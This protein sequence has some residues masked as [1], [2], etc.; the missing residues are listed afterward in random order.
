MQRQTSERA[1]ILLVAMVQFVNILDFMMVMPMGP[2][3]AAALGIPLSR[4]GLIGG[5]YTLAAM[6]SGLVGSLF[7]DRFGRR[8]ALLVAMLGLVVA[9]VLGGLA[10]G[11]STLLLARVIAGAFGGP[12]TAVSMS[13][14]AD[15]VP[16]ERRGKAMGVVMGAFSLASVFGVPLGLE[17]ARRG[18]W[19]LPFFAVASLGLVATAVGAALLPPLR[20]HLERRASPTDG[21]AA[22]YRDAPGAAAA[23]PSPGTL[24]LLRRPAV[25]LTYAMSV[26]AML[27]GFVLIPNISPYLL[28]NLGYPREHLGLLYLCG[29]LSSF[30][31]LQ[32][33][34]RL[35]DRFGGLRIAAPA[36]V[37]IVWVV[38]EGFGRAR[39]WMP[40]IAV[41]VLWMTAM[42]F[43]NVAMQTVAS[44]VPSPTERARFMSLQSA[45]QHG[46]SAL[47]AMVSTLMLTEGADHRMVGMPRV[48]AVTATL[49][50]ALPF[51]LGMVERRQR[52]Q[53]RPG[54]LAG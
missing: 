21:L 3:F 14:I 17:L 8:N 42:S 43:R 37:I 38:I 30:V 12:A 34:G 24:D 51:L 49:F 6:I 27:G 9:T 10:R 16:A 47:G 54:A 28:H 4:L 40:V 20:G 22:T 18:G 45:V 26:T 48:A 5:S 44:K 52:A 25:L 50:A 11:F 36:T 2:D 1:V 33:A 7:L 41:F 23:Q 39:P 53:A 15:T 29:G 35:V 32:F 31:G 19:R 46:A 13:I